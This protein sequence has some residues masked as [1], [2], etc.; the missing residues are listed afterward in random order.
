MA[1]KHEARAHYGQGSSRSLGIF[2]SAS[3]ARKAADSARTRRRTGSSTTYT[4][5]KKGK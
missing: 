3:D 5:K 2:G 1:S 4:V